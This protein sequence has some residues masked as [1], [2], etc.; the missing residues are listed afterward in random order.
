M[1]Q[2]DWLR[3]LTDNEL[4]AIVEEAGER[5]EFLDAP[6]R[7]LINDELRRRKMPLLGFGKSRM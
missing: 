4:K 7:T 1:P 3:G 6:T 2:E 5:A